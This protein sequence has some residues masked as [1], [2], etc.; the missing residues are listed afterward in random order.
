LV[1]TKLESKVYKEQYEQ[2]KDEMNNHEQR[3]AE[4]TDDKELAKAKN[5]EQQDEINKLNDN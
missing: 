2:Y 5:E 1:Q 3:I 4:I